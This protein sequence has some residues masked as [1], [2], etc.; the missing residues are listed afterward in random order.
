MDEKKIKYE[1]WRITEKWG[2]SSIVFNCEIVEKK[3][4]VGVFVSKLPSNH[5]IDAVSQVRQ[6]S[7]YSLEYVC[8]EAGHCKYTAYLKLLRRIR[9]LDEKIKFLKKAAKKINKQ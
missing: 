1:I 6:Y 3:Y 2:Y 8:C 5:E 9:I 7:K 4:W